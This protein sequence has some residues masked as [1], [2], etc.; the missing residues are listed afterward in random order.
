MKLSRITLALA[1]A[2]A[3][4]HGAARAEERS[5]NNSIFVEGLGP[6][7]LY[8]LNFERAFADDFAL[9]IGASFASLGADVSGG[10]GTVSAS[11]S[12]FTVPVIANYLGIRSG[13][14]VLEL[15]AGGVW[16]HASGSASSGG[17]MASG[18]GDTLLGTAVIGYRRQPLNGGFMFRIG[19]S[20]LAGNGLG[21]DT[22]DP[23]KFGVVPW[24]YM[25]LGTTF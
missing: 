13:N 19:V 7:V 14:S 6:G 17:I 1:A 16:L 18:A 21:L 5:A 22:K 9:R 15:G 2:A 20:A 4:A 3:L 24:P 10:A 11:A 23:T 25:S 12:W 8:S